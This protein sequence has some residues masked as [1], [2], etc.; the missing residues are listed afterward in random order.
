MGV[1]NLSKK[2]RPS[3]VTPDSVA[4]S[5]ILHGKVIG[6]DYFVLLHK[7]IATNDGA[8]EYHVKPSIPNSVVEQRCNRV[9]SYAKANNIKFAVAV[10]G[11]YHPMKSAENNARDAD[12]NNAQSQLDALFGMNNIND[13]LTNDNEKRKEAIKLMKRAVRV[14]PDIIATGVRIFKE[15]GHDVYGAPFEADW[16]LVYWEK[17]GFTQ[18][19]IS[20]D[21]DIWAMG[22]ELF[23]DLLD[24]TSAD[25]K[26]VVLEREKVKGNVMEGSDQWEGKHFLLYAALCGC[27]FIKR[28]FKLEQAKIEELMTKHTDPNNTVPL[29]QLLGEISAGRHWPAG[30]RKPGEPATDFVDK[31]HTC[32][33][34]MTHAPVFGYCDGILQIVP[35]TPLP[36]DKVWS[37]V[38]GFDPIEIYATGA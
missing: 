14:T 10:D 15:N 31:V 24:Y 8:G 18:G 6:L 28:L 17:T 21:S 3:G 13:L 19:T 7:S 38:I 30:N 16:Q 34:L 1:T 29:D 9:C 20:I 35:M 11:K 27:D 26:C 32:I 12:R 36:E 37:D 5:Q 25:G 33:G 4:K 23:V 22:S 2:L